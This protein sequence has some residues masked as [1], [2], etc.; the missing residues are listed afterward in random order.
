MIFSGRACFRPLSRPTTTAPLL[1][2]AGRARLPSQMPP[3]AGRQSHQ[4]ILIARGVGG[5]E[6]CVW[7]FS[8]EPSRLVSRDAPRRSLYGQR[9]SGLMR[10]AR[11]SVSGARVATGG[12]GSAGRRAVRGTQGMPMPGDCASIEPEPPFGPQGGCRTRPASLMTDSWISQ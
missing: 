6:H 12:A 3:A 2:H 5:D 11:S 8:C 10:R 1:A 9:R 7:F 4:E